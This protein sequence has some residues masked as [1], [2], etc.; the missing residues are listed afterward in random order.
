MATTTNGCR[1]FL[2]ATRGYGYLT[3]QGAPQS[4]QVQHIRF[5]PQIEQRAPGQQ[6][7]IYPGGE[8]PTDITSLALAHSQSG[9]R[10][11]PGL[12]FCFVEKGSAP[13]ITQLFVSGPDTGRLAAQARDLSAQGTKYFE[14][15]CW[16]RLDSHA[17]DIGLVTKP[18]GAAGQPIGFGNELA[19]QFDQPP[20]EVAILTN[21]GIYTVRRRRLVDIFAAAIRAQAGSGDEAFELEM[22][23][24]I[25][26]YGR[27]ETTATALAVACGQG[28]DA[29]PTDDSNRVARIST[30]GFC[31]V[32]WSAIIE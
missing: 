26:Q 32:W 24:F 8:P 21:T 14:H 6:L 9:L 13:G 29:P 15:A 5:P 3:G 4:M 18:F 17:E 16:L 19:V 27:G 23:K 12:F 22:K 25:R 10:I 30:K 11:P 7:Q 31:R 20:Q 28:N 2:S 1:L